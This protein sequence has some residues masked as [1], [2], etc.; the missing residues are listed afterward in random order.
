LELTLE[1]GI[2][3]FL[4]ASC[5]MKAIQKVRGRLEGFK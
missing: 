2:H 3:I 5:R 1:A 4:Y